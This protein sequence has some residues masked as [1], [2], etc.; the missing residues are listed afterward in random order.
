MRPYRIS[1][2]CEGQTEVVFINKLNRFL[3]NNHAFKVV[4]HPE[5]KGVSKKISTLKAKVVK[6][7]K[8]SFKDFDEV[9]VWVDYDVFKR[10]GIE[11]SEVELAI[12]NISQGRGHNKKSPTLLLNY[13]NGEDF[14]I[15]FEEKDLIN[16]WKKICTIKQHF[17]TPMTASQYTK[18]YTQLIPNYCK[19]KVD[20]T[21]D[22]NSLQ[23]F[24]SLSDDDNITF[25]RDITKLLS[26]VLLKITE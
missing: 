25:K 17:D 18:P 21:I 4:L 5:I 16:K 14:L 23:R 7:C 6:H 1:V 13:M 19:G 11:S 15:L 24:I 2:L 20:A 3:Q 8:E 22:E 12:N 9:F 26:I 10:D